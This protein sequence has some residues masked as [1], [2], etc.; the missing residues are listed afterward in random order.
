MEGTGFKGTCVSDDILKLKIMQCTCKIKCCHLYKSIRK[1]QNT[2]K[3]KPTKDTDDLEQRKCKRP[4]NMKN[5]QPHHQ[6][7]RNI[8]LN[9]YEILF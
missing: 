5:V 6:F 9:G 1:R 7:K 2:P 4:V 3:K 8:K